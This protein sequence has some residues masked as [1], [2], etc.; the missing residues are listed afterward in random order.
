MTRSMLDEKTTCRPRSILPATDVPVSACRAIK[1]H[2][3]NDVSTWGD[4]PRA[5]IAD[6]E[7]RRNNMNYK[8][9][10][11]VLSVAVSSAFLAAFLTTGG[12]RI[13]AAGGAFDVTFDGN[14]RLA[15]D[16]GEEDFAS[17]M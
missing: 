6:L 2:H 7:M 9:T 11:W 3:L 17:D 16:F 8:K 15:T 12:P 13:S 5:D 4:R 10:R 14:G 1:V